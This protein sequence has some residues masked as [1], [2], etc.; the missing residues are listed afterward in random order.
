MDEGKKI[1]YGGWQNDKAIRMF[2]KNHC[3]YNGNLVHE[4]VETNGRTS[5]LKNSLEHYS[6][7]DFDNYNN[8]LNLYSKLQAE[9]LY[10]K[11]QKPNFYHFFVRPTYRFFWQYI[12]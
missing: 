5:I 4:L 12:F 1:K 8:K 2:N 10:Q 6:Y 9:N 11:K 7:K 3:A